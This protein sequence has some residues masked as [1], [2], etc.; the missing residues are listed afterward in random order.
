[1][2]LPRALTAGVGSE[3]LYTTRHRSQHS[4]ASTLVPCAHLAIAA[5]VIAKAVMSFA[6]KGAML[7]PHFL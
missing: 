4:N 1:M 2:Y 7:T 6:F 3:I 5:T